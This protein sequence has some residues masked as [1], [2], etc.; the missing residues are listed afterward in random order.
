[1]ILSLLKWL[2]GAVVL[3]WAAG[4][5]LNWV[6]PTEPVDLTTTVPELPPTAELDQWLSTQEEA[7]PNLRDGAEKRIVWAGDVGEQTPLS[8]VYLH[9]FSAS[10]E[11]I[12]PVPDEVAEQLGANL[13]FARLTGHGADG[14]AMAAVSVNAWAND[15]AEAVA[16]GREL[17]ERVIL[18]GTSTGATLA[19]LAA[20]DPEMAADL[21][22][23]VLLSPNFRAAGLGGRVIEWPYAR[24]W[25]PMVVG[26]ERAFEPR[27]EAHGTYWTT[28]YPTTS[29]ATLGAL[30]HYVR[31]LD[32]A[33]MTVPALFLVSTS[34]QV[35]D[36]RAARRAAAAWG[37]RSV[38]T[39]VVMAPEDDPA[40]HVLA[41]DALS[42][43][44]TARVVAGIVAWIR[45]L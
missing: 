27:N 3:V 4:A 32:L 17:G 6:G 30:Q 12:R 39:P 19:V 14:A 38:L 33:E 2:I 41:G 18:M 22:A 25:G 40:G 34:D 45:Q 29:L 37:A 13:Y 24:I 20:S 16:I 28:Q 42:P 35:V 7:V 11:E 8:L 9:G 36:S 26:A 5:V 1:M 15:V 31:G 44:K 10:S 43:G 21:E 23:L